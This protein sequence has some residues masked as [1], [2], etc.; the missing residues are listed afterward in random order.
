MVAASARL[1]ARQF[2]HMLTFHNSL[3]TLLFIQLV[4]A[5]VLPN[6]DV[7]AFVYGCDEGLAAPKMICTLVQ[8]KERIKS[9]TIWISTGFLSLLVKHSFFLTF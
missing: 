8:T 4:L 2:E 3:Y 9:K 6:L 7:V 1:L 5:A